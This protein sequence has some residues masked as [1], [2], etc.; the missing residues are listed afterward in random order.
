MP[1]DLDNRFEAQ[2]DRLVRDMDERMELLSSS[3]LDQ[4]K[5]SIGFQD[6][7]SDNPDLNI[8]SASAFPRRDSF[9]SVPEPPQQ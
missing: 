6:S 8:H 2:H 5:T 1:L 9:H 3:L 7:Q 4:I